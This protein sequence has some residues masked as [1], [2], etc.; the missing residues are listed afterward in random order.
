MASPG[1]DIYI[2]RERE[3]ERKI[4]P[5]VTIKL[6]RSRS[7]II[8]II[9]IEKNHAHSTTRFARFARQLLIYINNIISATGW[10]E[11]LCTC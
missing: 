7:P 8:Y 6:A 10:K 4:V 2:Y 3:R 11:K 5:V 1:K 9:N